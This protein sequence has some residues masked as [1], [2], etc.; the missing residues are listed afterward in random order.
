[1]VIVDLL[2][3]IK[4]KGSFF[5]ILSLCLLAA[6]AA[7]CG[8]GDAVEVGRLRCE[9]LDNPVGIG[10]TAPRLSWE[11]ASD[12]RGV[13]QRAYRI[14]VASSE[15]EL[16]AGRGDRWDSGW[17]RSDATLGI[18]Y[19]GTPL[20]SRDAC[21]WKVQVKTDKGR[22]A[23]SQPARWTTAL[24]DSAEWTARWIGL[25]RTFDGDRTEGH[26]RLAARYLRKEFEAS[27]E[28]RKATLHICGLGMY[29]AYINGRRIGTQVH[30]PT[31]TDYDRS[32]RYNT[33]DVTG[34]VVPGGNAIGVVL[35]NGRYFTARYPDIRHFGFPKMLLQLEVEYADGTRR[36][37]VSDDS[38][39]VT[40]EG[41][42]R[43]NNE[44]DGERYDA[45]LEMPGWN[46]LGY[47]D[48]A[49]FPVE[50]VPAPAGRLEAQANPHIVITDT[51]RP[52]AISRLRPGVYILDMGQNMVGWLSMR[53]QGR[54]GQEVRLRF[55]E[56]LRPDG[57]LYTDN[58]RSAQATDSYTAA[59]DGEHRWEPSFVYHGFRYVEVTGY[60]GTPSLSDFVGKAVCDRMEQTGHFATSD[61][62]IN[63]VYRNAFRGIRGNY[64][65]MPTDCP[66]R[67]ER[68]GW[69]GDR[70]AGAFGESYVFDNG[71]LY[72]KW[73]QDIEETQRANG[74]I[75]DV[76]PNYWQVYNDDVTWPSAYLLCAQMLYERFGDTAP[77]EKHYASMK[78]W[79]DYMRDAYMDGHIIARDTY[80]DWCMPPESPEL[81][82]SQD[83]A[84]KTDG[85]LL[86]T[87]TYYHLLG[88]M[89]GFARL[90][91]HTDDIDGFRQQ[92]EA[93]REAYNRKFFDPATGGYSNNTVTA[94]L[95]SL[96]YG[97]VPEASR[98]SVF[99][100]I[101]DKTLAENGG[102]V[103]TGLVGIR[104]L[105]RGLT[106]NG[107]A[108]IAL[109]LATNRDYP[110]WGYMAERGATTIW[111]L[112]NGD[113]ADPA[114]NSAN[115]VMLLGDLVV[116]YYECLA[117]IR[118]APGSAAFRQL[119]LKPYPVEGLDRVDASYRSVRGPIVSRWTKNAGMFDWE[120]TVPANAS[121]TV[122][123]PGCDP[124]SVREGDRAARRAAG[125]KYLRTE[126]GYTVFEIGS[127]SY[128]FTA[129]LPGNATKE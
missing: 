41:P 109:R 94:N 87:A 37:V 63:R 23:W 73:L 82:H 50:T 51:V 3:E 104:H 89:E 122:Y 7:S 95:L 112:W 65:G 58:L 128:R 21:Y 60:P 108:D 77:I 8:R 53:V 71:L 117:G 113:T 31:P 123:V 74:S 34:A 54:R 48:S 59:D 126:P 76:A 1:M 19:G 11:L 101:V 15:E 67:D 75:S 32:V 110:S 26:T 44:F 105:M 13:V 42:I 79:M 25:D 45:R 85:A 18:V 49:W 106:Y 120:V 29:E 64:H 68:M 70:A 78:K 10:T 12:A 52:V 118:N 28:V 103:S 116:W 4:M 61:S 96:V 102:H 6:F 17:V 129:P 55:A 88:L 125:V 98:A 92:A 83:P 114:M 99:G 124:A 9:M 46:E 97:L 33:F 20:G 43:A 90:A 81:I 72:A 115:H 57:S 127:G 16:A 66:Q 91:G 35:G 2:N 93:V 30:A 40:A 86:S 107:R 111:E 39:R 24:L 38:W 121:A 27:A 80:G 5:R 22:T 56:S 84:R 47:D 14:L 119:V 36:T 69:L 62:T 100:H